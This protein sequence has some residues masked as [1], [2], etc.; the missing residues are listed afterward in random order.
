MSET[1]RNRGDKIYVYSYFPTFLYNYQEY[2]QFF[3]N[4]YFKFIAD[5]FLISA[6]SDLCFFFVLK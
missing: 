6:Q 3:I 4:S 2:E 5:V 1:L